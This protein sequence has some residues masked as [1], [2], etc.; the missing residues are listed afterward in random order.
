MCVSLPACP[1]PPNASGPQ[2]RDFE[3]K[4]KYDMHE[5]EPKPTVTLG[6]FERVAIQ[7]L[8]SRQYAPDEPDMLLAAWRVLDTEGK[9]YLDV[10][11]VKGMFKDVGDP[12][13]SDAEVSVLG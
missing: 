2:P 5:D 9:G 1:F 10:G 8:D 13:F 7:L 11:T 6:G 3:D 4:I 12:G